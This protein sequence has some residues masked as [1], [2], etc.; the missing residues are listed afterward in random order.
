MLQKSGRPRLTGKKIL[1]LR[2]NEEED[3]EK[4]ESQKDPLNRILMLM[5]YHFYQITA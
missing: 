2:Q 4:L 3:E 5:L 1:P